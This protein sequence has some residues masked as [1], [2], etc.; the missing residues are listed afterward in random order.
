MSSCSVDGMALISDS[1]SQIGFRYCCCCSFSCHPH[2]RVNIP[3]FSLISPVNLISSIHVLHSS[4]PA[5]ECPPNGLI[6][7][8]ISISF[9]DMFVVPIRRQL[10][11]YI[12]VIRNGI[13]IILSHVVHNITTSSGP[14]WT[15]DNSCNRDGSMD[16]GTRQTP[17]RNKIDGIAT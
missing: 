17:N 16:R 7:L 4:S 12:I 1:R 10:D 13:V 8:F 2:R 15:W 5:Q 6:F 3:F 9:L 11:Y 14:I